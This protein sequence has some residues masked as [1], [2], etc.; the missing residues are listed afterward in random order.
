MIRI[1]N[2]LEGDFFDS[3][4]DLSEFKNNYKPLL[5]KKKIQNL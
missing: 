1:A 4:E 5:I 2:V 3:V